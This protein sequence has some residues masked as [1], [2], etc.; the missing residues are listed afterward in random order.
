VDK[1]LQ[2]KIDILE[3]NI[4][5]LKTAVVAFSGGVDSTFLL[6]ITSNLLGNN[7]LAV[8]LQT[9][10]HSQKEINEAKKIAKSFSIPHHL[11]KI[12]ITKIKRFYEN[13]SDRCYHCKKYMFSTIIDFAKSHNISSVLEGSNLDDLDQYRPG[14]KALKELG[15]LSPLVQANLTKQDIRSLSKQFH[16]STWDKPANPCLATRIPYNTR[17]SE[18]ILNQIEKAEN[19]LYSLGIKQSRVRY[20]HEIARIEVKKDDM[21]KILSSADNIIKSFKKLGF[22][23]ITIDIEGYRSGSLDEVL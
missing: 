1:E 2:D 7:C 18:D 3:N 6:K 15:I 19:V 5:K 16:L 14:L 8:T 23:Y 17:I 12:D 11:L 20:H 13:P 10:A 4:K 9:S 21:K 22:K